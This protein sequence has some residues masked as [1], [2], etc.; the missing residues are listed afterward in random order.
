MTGRPLGQGLFQLILAKRGLATMLVAVLLH[1]L[2]YTYG[3]AS[4]AYG[5]LEARVRP[6][7]SSAASATASK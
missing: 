1:Q 4:F 2:Y 7:R 3:V 6:R 5:Q